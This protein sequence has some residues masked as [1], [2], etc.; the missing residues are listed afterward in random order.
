MNI[1]LYIGD[2]CK[3]P[4]E[5]ICTS[6]NPHLELMAGT[7]GAVRDAGGWVIQEECN[8]LIDA[9]KSKSGNKYLPMGS[10]WRTGAG[11]LPFRAVIHCVAADPFHS[12]TTHIIAECVQNLLREAAPLDPP[13]RSIAMPVFASGHV[14]H[15]FKQALESMLEI[16]LDVHGIDIEHCLIAILEER[17]A[18]IAKQ[19][20]DSRLGTFDNICGEK[21]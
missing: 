21:Q 8:E 12:S 20:L 13:I 6:T 19:I 5:V 9:E 2:I 11:S 17:H 1:L 7:G 14:E 15:D 4:V 16:L 10:A 18:S 3:A